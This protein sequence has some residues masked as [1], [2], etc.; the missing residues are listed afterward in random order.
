MTVLGVICLVV[1]FSLLTTFFYA[2]SEGVS[3]FQPLFAI[4]ITLPLI[5]AGDCVMIDKREYVKMC[6]IYSLKNDSEISGSFILGSG[7]IDESEV[8]L[9]FYKTKEGYV[10]GE[11]LVSDTYIKEVEGEPAALYCIYQ[12]TRSRFGFFN[13]DYYKNKTMH[14][15]KYVLRVPKGT[16]VQEFKVY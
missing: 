7:S 8:Y 12:Y 11:K 13:K 6:N 3:I 10:R 9:Y 16:I 15:G 1:L 5:F 14:N 2:L 4:G